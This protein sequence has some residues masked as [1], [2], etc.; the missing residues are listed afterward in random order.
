MSCDHNPYDFR[1]TKY[2]YVIAL[3][4]ILDEPFFVVGKDGVILGIKSGLTC[5]LLV[6]CASGRTASSYFH[7]QLIGV[8]QNARGRRRAEFWG[9]GEPATPQ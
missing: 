2:P 7:P 9:E 3:A 8:C 1:T 4:A 6:L 5:I